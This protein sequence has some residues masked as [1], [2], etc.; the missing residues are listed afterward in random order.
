LFVLCVHNRPLSER[1][2]PSS[3]PWEDFSLIESNYAAAVV[4]SPRPENIWR[5][6]LAP[7]LQNYARFGLPC[8]PFVP[9]DFRLDHHLPP[10]GKISKYRPRSS[11][12]LTVSFEGIAFRSATSVSEAW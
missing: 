4:C 9:W 11:K 3:N 2:G 12:S 8:P 10:A 6:T 7:L 5:T 1:R